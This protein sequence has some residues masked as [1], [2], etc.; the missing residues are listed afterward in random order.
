MAFMQH[1]TRALGQRTLSRVPQS[2]TTRPM[3]AGTSA[4]QLKRAGSTGAAVKWLPA[5]GPIRTLDLNETYFGDSDLLGLPVV[6]ELAILSLNNTEVTHEGLVHLKDFP[7]L[8][9]LSLN[10]TRP[11]S[12]ISLPAL[13]RLRKLELQGAKLNDDDLAWIGKLNALEE[14][15]LAD[16]PIS[17]KGF[18]YFGSLSALRKLRLTGT[19]VDDNGLKCLPPLPNLR[20]LIIERVATLHGSGF[21]SV[22]NQPSLEELWIKDSGVDSSAFRDFDRLTK[23]RIISAPGTAIGSEAIP[24]LA[25]LPH[26]K[27]LYIGG[28]PI[29]D[30]DLRTLSEAPALE[31]LFVPANPQ[32]TDAGLNHLVKAKALKELNVSATSTSKSGRADFKRRRPDVHLISN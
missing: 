17:G 27:E 3:V 5:I 12:L 31:I 1:S 7:G 6:K 23:L 26:L 22:A 14:L 20:E 9:E 4:L 21:V 13:P 24:T 10:E 8:T 15:N 19:H 30:N 2:L 16:T 28:T 25:R 29:T 11:N 18:R 32:L